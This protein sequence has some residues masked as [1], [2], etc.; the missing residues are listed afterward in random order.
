MPV[1][2]I[3]TLLWR[4]HPPDGGP[5]TAAYPLETLADAARDAG[6]DAVG[7]DTTTVEGREADDVARVLRERGLGCTDVGILFLG[8]SRTLAEA[9]RLA[10]LAAATGAGACIAVPIRPYEPAALVDELAACAEIL[11]SA[12]ARLALEFV[13]YAHLQ[14]LGE[15]IDLC[16]A[17]G[18]ERCGVLLDIWHFVRSGA[19]WDTLRS[20]AGEQIALVHADDAPEPIADPDHESR[21]RRVPIGEGTFPVGAFVQ[22]LEEIGYAGPVSVE[23]LSAEL[24]AGPPLAYARALRESARAWK[25]AR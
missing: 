10:G 9:E 1:W 5:A 4:D 22:V 23:V 14:T 17:T 6:F 15:A 2:S 18:W 13:P 25:P 19:P 7:I 24:K 11:G 20:L 8:R 3:P 16:A 21:F 12:G